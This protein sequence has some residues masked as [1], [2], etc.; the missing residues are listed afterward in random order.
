MISVCLKPFRGKWYAR[1]RWSFDGKRYEKLVPLRTKSKVTARTRLSDVKKKADEI[2]ELYYKGESYSFPWMNEEGKTKVEYLTLEDAVEKWFKLRKAQGIAESTLERNRHSMNT[3]MS[4]LGKSIRLRSLTTTHIDGYTERMALKGYS[5]YGININ[6][7][8]FITFL[9][10]AERRNHIDKMPYVEKAKV[11]DS[12]PSYLN[13]S[14]F[15]GIMKHTNE[16]FERVFKMYRNTG[17]RLT[18]PILGTLNND[19]LVIS[20]KYSKTRKERRILLNPEDVP[21]IY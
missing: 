21:V 13:D 18:E 9:K 10:W 5:P 15:N 4:V 17:F 1:V 19:T 8:A 12:L 20:A 6:L 2:V 16:H 3:I 7:R 14:E 11:D